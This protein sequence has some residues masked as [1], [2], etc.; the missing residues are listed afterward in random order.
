MTYENIMYIL[1]LLKIVKISALSFQYTIIELRI[2]SL[3]IHLVP[4]LHITFA[5][6]LTSLGARTEKQQWSDC[7]DLRN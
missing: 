4:V 3:A 6:I 5:D 2:G 1:S 7:G